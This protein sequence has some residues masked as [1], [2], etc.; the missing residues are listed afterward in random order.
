MQSRHDQR[1]LHNLLSPLSALEHGKSEQKYKKLYSM[2]NMT[3]AEQMF[4]LGLT[5]S[6]EQLSPQHCQ[7]QSVESPDLSLSATALK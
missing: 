5:V 2:Q 3:A 7:P 4:H 6:P 1:N